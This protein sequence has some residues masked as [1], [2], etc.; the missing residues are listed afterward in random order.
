MNIISRYLLRALTQAT[1]YVLFAFAALYAIFDLIEE[2]ENI[3]RGQF[4][5]GTLFQY[6]AWRVPLYLYEIFPIAVLIGALIALT[7]L[8]STS[9]YAVMRTAGV[10]MRRII[11]VLCAFALGC[12]LVNTAIGEWLMPL[13]NRTADN[14]AYN[15]M[16]GKSA[17]VTKKG[18]LWLKSGNDMVQVNAM[19]PDNTLRGVMRYRLDDDFRLV[20]LETAQ[21]A[22]YTD[23]GLWRL[24]NVAAT[25]FADERTTVRRAAA[26]SW[27]SNINPQLLNVLIVNPHQMSI[28]ALGDYI[29]HLRDNKQRTVTYEVTR[30]RKIFYPFGA[31]A[32]VLVAL[33][34]TPVIA[35]HSSMGWRIFF[36]MCLGVGFHFIGRF[37]GFYA[38]LFHLPPLLAGGLPM[39]LFILLAVTVT[40][41]TQKQR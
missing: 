36:G 41:W 31:L 33:S 1:L 18:G 35:R 37:F 21:T 14:L 13:G 32:M 3:G 2:S 12:A 6:V 24:N 30:W 22:Q 16:H 17:T 38:E 34:F 9:E 28:T 5:A 23:D 10:S 27:Y 8:S 25:D 19:L 29:K 26:E 39:T 4:S 40:Y 20:A 11:G 7:R 15:A